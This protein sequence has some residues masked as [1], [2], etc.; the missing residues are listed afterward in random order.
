MYVS[1]PGSSHHR[2]PH[3][4]QVHKGVVD[5][6]HGGVGVGVHGAEHHA[7]DAPEPI[8]SHADR[9]P[10]AEGRRESI[11]KFAEKEMKR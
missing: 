1:D 5:G 9:H 10:G 7:P 8:D 4:F 11:K 2:L 6:N 3:V